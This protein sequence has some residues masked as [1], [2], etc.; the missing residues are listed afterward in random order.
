MKM[1]HLA[2][3]AALAVLLA[4]IVPARA[5]E[6]DWAYHS[7]SGE[8]QRA[9][10]MVPGHDFPFI[11]NRST[12]ISKNDPITLYILTANQ[13]A[14]DAEEQVYVRWWNGVEEYWVAASWADNLIFGSSGEGAGLFR[15][16]PEFGMVMVDLWKVEIPAHMTRLGDNYYVIQIKGWS[17]RGVIEHY[18]VHNA[19][20]P[21][22]RT[23]NVGQAWVAE[24]TYM[25]HDWCIRITE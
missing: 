14:G 15:G 2:C 1:L 7:A 13:F 18:L 16:Q 25:G 5:M 23:N 6:L 11:A 8:D 3:F 22:A 10:E 9:A 12:E 19:G 17:D 21:G 4:G 20:T 24:P